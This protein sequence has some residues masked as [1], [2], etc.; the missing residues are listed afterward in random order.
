MPAPR[1]RRPRERQHRG[2]SLVG[3]RYVVEV[4][5]IAHGGHFIARYEG[6]VL[7]VRHAITGEQVVAEVTE[8]AEGDRFL[9]ADAIEV[10][11]ASPDRVEAPCPVA[12]PG[13]CG[14]CDFQHVALDAQRRL[15]A[16]VLQE[17]LRRLAGIQR[18][19]LVEA[20]S[21]D[22]DPDLDAGLRWRT[23][24]QWASTSDGHRGLFKHRSHEVIPVDDCLIARTDARSG[25]G[26]VDL[27]ARGRT[28]EVEGDGFWQIHPGAP[29]VLVGTVLDGLQPQPGDSVVDLYSGVGLFSVFLAEAVGET[30]SVVGIEG[31]RVATRHADDNLAPYPWAR[32]MSSDVVAG[33]AELGEQDLVVLDPPREGAKR[34]VVEA[35]VAL[36]PRRV[37]YV[38]CDPAALARDLS[39]FA[40]LGFELVSLRAFDLFPMT[41]HV[42]CVALLT[43]TNSDLR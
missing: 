4:G 12:G 24:V 14:G 7:F 29:E 35:I 8:G 30:G 28:F 36:R 16:Q 26:V 39:Y 38:A 15:K 33:L 20:V 3:E 13:L 19:V 11:R 27:T 25:P 22:A 21:A 34:K 9:R 17:Q 43:K 40:E 23:R 37:A 5:P 18:D 41:H 1:S 31:D 10:L 32:A 6:R 42:E 2:R